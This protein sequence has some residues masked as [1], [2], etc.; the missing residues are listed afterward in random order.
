MR[1]SGSNSGDV[2]AFWQPRYTRRLRDCDARQI[3]ENMTE[4]FRVLLDWEETER[5]EMTAGKIVDSDANG[6]NE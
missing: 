5:K 1:R 2:L 4:F 6:E 3:S